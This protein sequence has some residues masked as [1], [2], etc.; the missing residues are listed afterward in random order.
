VSSDGVT[1]FT[2]SMPTFG[3]SQAAA[4]ANASLTVD[5]IPIS[6]ASNTVTGA[7]GGVT[8]NL[9]NQ[10][11]GSQVNL[12]LSSDTTQVSNA[13]QSF[14]TDYNS[15][16]SLVNTQFA[17]NASTG[18]QG[19]LGGDSTVRD[20]QSTLL[21]ALSYTATGPTSVSSLSSLGISVNN[22]GT[23]AVDSTTLNNAVANNSTDVQSFFQGPSLNGFATSLSGQLDNL[24]NP[25]TG[26]FTI[27]LSSNSHD[28]QD[29]ASHISDFES[30]YIARQQTSL[31][32]MYSKAEI[33]L[34]QLPTQMSQIQAELGNNSQGK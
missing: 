14:V 16:I 22:D 15:A 3:F 24:T 4:G 29:L 5:G 28:Y 10:T 26:A 32:A 1:P 9:L 13:I 18:S 12:S 25:A 19:V 17:Y 34:Q 30:I 7:I 2:I 33:A 21:G 11:A 27:D 31:T 20:L 8:L 23:L 6:S